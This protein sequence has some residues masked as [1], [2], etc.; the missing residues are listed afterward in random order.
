ME[1]LYISVQESWSDTPSLYL[2]RFI[3]ILQD[4]Y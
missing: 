1:I 3:L 2:A 4:L